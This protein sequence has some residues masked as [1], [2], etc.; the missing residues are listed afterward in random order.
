MAVMGSGYADLQARKARNASDLAGMDKEGTFGAFSAMT[1]P[2]KYTYMYGGGAPNYATQKYV[3]GRFNNDMIAAGKNPNEWVNSIAGN[4]G[5]L[6]APSKA[7]PI[8]LGGMANNT[9][10]FLFGRRDP[11]DLVAPTYQNG[12]PNSVRVGEPSPYGSPFGGIPG[13]APNSPPLGTD[14]RMAP[15]GPGF[16]EA[17]GNYTGGMNLS[18]YLDPSYQFARDEGLNAVKNSYA[19]AGNF[20]SGPAMKGIADYGAGTALNKAWQPAFQNYMQDKN[21]NLGVDTGDRN[22]AYNA[23]VGD[24]NFNQGNNLALAQLG[25]QGTQGQ[26][27]LAG[28]LAQLLSSNTLAGGQAQGAGA[29][30]QGNV[31]NSTIS[32][33]IAQMMGNRQINDIAGG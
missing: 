21:F 26:S 5:D 11:G 3:S 12:S 32:Q 2:Q 1:D 33:I 17:S 22:F 9:A 8:T 30:G 14:P 20:L 24:R 6:M 23:Q 18:N 29:V 27:G 28:I 19:G 13:G 15:G 25:M 4:G 16:N 10:P 7:D 31:L